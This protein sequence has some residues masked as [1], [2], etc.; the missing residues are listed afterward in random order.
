[1]YIPDKELT[2][3]LGNLLDNAID[4]AKKC[5]SGFIRLEMQQDGQILKIH[6]ENNY[7]GKIS[8][9]NNIFITSKDDPHHL[10]GLGIKNVRA[11]VDRLRGHMNISYTDETFT[12]DLLLPNG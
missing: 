10:H 11:T 5:D 2:T 7:I 8:E 6:I 9:S 3:I 4:A 12:V 1:M